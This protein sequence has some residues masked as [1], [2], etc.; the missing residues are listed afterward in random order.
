MDGATALVSGSHRWA[1]ERDPTADEIV[2]AVM[3]AG[4]LLVYLG[5]IGR[6]HV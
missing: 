5:E 2:S 6:A 3:P 1:E 4:S